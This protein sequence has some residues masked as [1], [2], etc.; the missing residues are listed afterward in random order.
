MGKI[1][2]II[3]VLVLLVIT[4]LAGIIYTTDINQFK[5]QFVQ[6][7]KDKTGRDLQID[8]E[9]KLAL[10]LIPTITIEDVSLSNASWAS[11]QNM[12]SMKKFEVQISL[13]ALLKNNLQIVRITLI[14]PVINLEKNKD[15]IGNWILATPEPEPQELEKDS[16]VEGLPALAINEI[17]IKNAKIN[18]QDVKTGT[19]TTLNIDE[20]TLDSASDSDPV[21]LQ[22]Q[23]TINDTPLKLKATLGSINQLLENKTYPLEINAQLANAV[24]ML[25]GELNQPQT[26]RGIA[27]DVSLNIKNLSDLNKIANAELPDDGPF[28]LTGK[29]SDT[30]RGYEIK[31]M[32]AQLLDYHLTGQAQFE[33]SGARPKIIATLATETLDISPFQKES[34]EAPKKEKLFTST[35]F[36]LASFKAADVEIEFHSNKLITKSVIVENLKLGLKL[37]N[38]RLKLNQTG[39]VAGGDIAATVNLDASN[40]NNAI[41]QND[42]TIAQLELGQLPSIKEKGIISG[43]KTDIHIQTQ[44]QGSTI[45]EIMAGLNGKVLIKIG[46]GKIA[47]TLLDKGSTDLLVGMLSMLDPRAKKID[48][49]LLECAVVKFTIKDGIAKTDQGIALMTNQLQIVGSGTIDLKTEQLDIGFKPK[50][51][52]GFGLDLSQFAGLIRV[53][54][55]LTNPAPKIDAAAAL[56]T[57]LST[58]ADIA[59]G[60]LSL[61]AKKLF[62]GTSDDGNPCDAAL[63]IASNKQATP[64]KNTDDKIK[65]IIPDPTGIISDQ[66][67]KLF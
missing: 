13:L 56:T 35:P 42:M 32:R 49:S 24:V 62:D 5:G 67:K 31:D 47:S 25:S 59:T 17:Q 40:E 8:G 46:A 44:G 38:G 28:I 50:V 18:Y 51:S 52:Q 10:S 15:G 6:I 16:A 45:A 43:G 4:I 53:G 30:A 9:L 22:V 34:A 36:P 14:E 19:T 1:I 11:K 41:L 29:L 27:F 12:V 64:K 66:L 26:A 20:I 63:G 54:G 21:H 7:V 39:T 58:G 33:Q 61:L 3:A 37:N 55:T 57:G 60:G 2:K 23:A 65:D 48:G